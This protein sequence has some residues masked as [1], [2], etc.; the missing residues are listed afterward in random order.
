MQNL[1]HTTARIPVPLEE[2][3]VPEEEEEEEEVVVIPEE[4]EEEEGSEIEEISDEF[5][6]IYSCFYEK[7]NCF[8]FSYWLF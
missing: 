8:H 4:E 3:Y 5:R 1:L 7:F 2:F 6:G